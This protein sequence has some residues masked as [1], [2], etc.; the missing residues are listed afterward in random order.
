MKKNGNRL[1]AVKI[2]LEFDN[3]LQRITGTSRETIEVSEGT[4]FLMLLQA[5][6]GTY[7]AITQTYS[8]SDIGISL[9]GHAPHDDETL[10]A[11][12][13]VTLMITEDLD[14][15]AFWISS[16]YAH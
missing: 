16:E 15:E 7:H 10:T 4:P 14:E 5:V 1:K 9:N 12:D 11:H 2:Y 13:T 8:V 3:R 6:L